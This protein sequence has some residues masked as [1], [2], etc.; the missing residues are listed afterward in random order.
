MKY[1][2]LLTFTIFLFASCDNDPQ[3]ENYNTTITNLTLTEITHTHG[4]GKKNCF[5][6]HVKANLHSTDSL[7]TNLIDLARRRTNELGEEG[8]SL[9]H[10]K[11]G[12]E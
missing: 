8:C 3:Y 10:G 2:I 11:N 6:C 7:G 4:Y 1:F 9:C 5:S 12:V